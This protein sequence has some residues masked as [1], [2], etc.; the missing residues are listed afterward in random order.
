MKQWITVMTF[1]GYDIRILDG[2]EAGDIQDYSIAPPMNESNSY[3]TIDAVIKAIAARGKSETT[4]SEKLTLREKVERLRRPENAEGPEEFR[5]EKD[6]FEER[7]QEFSKLVGSRAEDEAKKLFRLLHVQNP[8]ARDWEEALKEF[9]R[10]NK[11][12]TDIEREFRYLAYMKFSE[13]ARREI[14]RIQGLQRGIS[15]EKLDWMK[16]AGIV[17]MEKSFRHWSSENEMMYSEEYLR[18]TPLEAIKAGY[19]RTARRN[20]SK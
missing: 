18:D 13:M 8:S 17:E 7:L 14:E 19:E 5:E 20:E 16:E 9:R 2:A 3:P 10:F 4:T 6:V 12:E 11:E 1:K 15:Q